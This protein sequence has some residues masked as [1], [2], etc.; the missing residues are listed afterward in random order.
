LNSFL[1]H[2]GEL[3]ED[4]TGAATGD[5]K[6][7]DAA[8][9]AA[10]REKE[11]EEE[12]DIFARG[13]FVDEEEDAAAVAAKKEKE[14]KEA[15]PQEH[16]DHTSTGQSEDG[17][18]V[19][20]YGS[21]L[22]RL[23][24]KSPAGSEADIAPS[25]YPEVNKWRKK[26]ELATVASDE[27]GTFAKRSAFLK[28]VDVNNWITKDPKIKD[29]LDL[30][31]GDDYPS[32]EF[33]QIP[34]S[35]DVEMAKARI[36]EAESIST[37]FGREPHTDWWKGAFLA[38]LYVVLHAREVL[39]QLI[40][41]VDV[42]VVDETT[43]KYNT[44]LVKRNEQSDAAKEKLLAI[45]HPL[46]FGPIDTFR[47]IEEISSKTAMA[48][49]LFN[50]ENLSLINNDD[51]DETANARSRLRMAMRS[52]IEMTPRMKQDPEVWG[53]TNKA[54]WRWKI[55]AREDVKAHISGNR[56]SPDEKRRKKESTI[57]AYDTYRGLYNL[58]TIAQK[59]KGPIE[60]ERDGAIAIERERERERARAIAI[61]KQPQSNHHADDDDENLDL[62]LG[63]GTNEGSSQVGA[64]QLMASQSNRRRAVQPPGRTS[65]KFLQDNTRRA[66][67]M[68]QLSDPDQLRRD[69]L[70]AERLEQDFTNLQ[71]GTD[72]LKKQVQ[73]LQGK[74]RFAVWENEAAVSL[75]VDAAKKE[76]IQDHEQEV[77][78]HEQE[79]KDLEEKVKDLEGESHYAKNRIERSYENRQSSTED[80]AQR[81]LQL[82]R[83]L[84]AAEK[85]KMIAEERNLSLNATIKNHNQETCEKEKKISR[86]Y[87]EVG[88]LR[89][90]G[91]KRKN[92]ESPGEPLAKKPRTESKHDA[93]LNDAIQDGITACED[94][95]PRDSVERSR[96]SIAKS[97]KK[98][99]YA[100]SESALGVLKNAL[101]LTTLTKIIID[102]NKMKEKITLKNKG[103]ANAQE[104]RTAAATNARET[105]TAATAATAAAPETATAAKPA[106]PKPLSKKASR[107]AAAAAVVVVAANSN[108]P[109]LS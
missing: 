38:S 86:L 71:N 76:W 103:N 19:E 48:D 61:G 81:L 50:N 94:V 67:I 109:P 1:P 8:A 29:A 3:G 30:V 82:T 92:E 105:A 69:V 60:R 66:K 79:V 47:Q 108:Q 70:D 91:A 9:V 72:L 17:D 24:A 35:D 56:V 18:D 80:H 84:E 13:A 54:Y 100:T 25:R 98:D 95:I 57:A 41:N 10:K 102:V 87:Q 85:A 7:E 16:Q 44:E 2:A 55:L 34:Q 63:S 12:A 36:L 28:K 68:Q 51:G 62:D 97:L 37:K 26:Q 78:D 40:T 107:K 6:K 11:E 58:A 49:D 101:L 64:L 83:K 74:M 45:D 96:L 89:S 59:E 65:V 75:A 33:N 20:D 99:D 77:K 4:S 73:I 88:E 23:N 22:H 52:T 32:T 106:L 42:K 104:R 21:Y 5:A 39:A 93:K 46:P 53:K 43:Q 15:H 31:Y 90:S 27:A 14:N